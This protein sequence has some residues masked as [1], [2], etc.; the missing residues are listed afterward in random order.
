[1]PFEV[2]NC[3][4]DVPVSDLLCPWC[5]REKHPGEGTPRLGQLTVELLT[6]FAAHDPG[7]RWECA[8]AGRGGL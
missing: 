4:S 3:A 7:R 1:L 2:F 5:A 6:A 8:H